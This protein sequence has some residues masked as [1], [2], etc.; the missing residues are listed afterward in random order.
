[1][2]AM[3]GERDLPPTVSQREGGAP[4]EGV[5]GGYAFVGLGEEWCSSA[6]EEIRTVVDIST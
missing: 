3:P 4:G 5:W 1:M 6:S 2:P